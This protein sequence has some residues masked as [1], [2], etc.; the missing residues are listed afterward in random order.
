MHSSN[1]RFY[2]LCQPISQIENCC[3]AW[4][5]LA[6]TER[7]GTGLV[8]SGAALALPGVSPDD[9][10]PAK[11]PAAWRHYLVGVIQGVLVRRL[12]AGGSWV[13]IYI[14]RNSI[15]QRDSVE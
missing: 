15:I 14:P 5:L 8:D 13:F 2:P 9:Q 3:R 7:P 10:L 12:E 1:D 4:Q 11:L 6:K